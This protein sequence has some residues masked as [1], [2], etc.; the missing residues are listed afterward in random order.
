[1]MFVCWGAGTREGDDERGKGAGQGRDQRGDVQQLALFRVMLDQLSSLAKP[2][3]HEIYLPP[4]IPSSRCPRGPSPRLPREAHEELVSKCLLHG[5]ELERT[6]PY[7]PTH[8]TAVTPSRRKHLAVGISSST[9]QPLTSEYSG[10]R[11]RIDRP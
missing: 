10:P 6:S 1:M 5:G 3:E 4:K 11:P 7:S 2:A 8:N 9:A